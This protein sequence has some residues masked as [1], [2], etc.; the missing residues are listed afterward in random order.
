MGSILPGMRNGVPSTLTVCLVL[1]LIGMIRSAC[2]QSDG[3]LPIFKR[4]QRQVMYHDPANLPPA[5]SYGAD[6]SFDFAPPRLGAPVEYRASRPIS[7]DEAIR[8]AL[9]N[10][11]VVRTLNGNSAGAS[12][13]T[14]YDAAIDNTRIDAAQAAFDPQF[15]LNQNWIQNENP[16]GTID[17]ATGLI[18]QGNAS[19]TYNVNVGVSQRNMLGGQ[20]SVTFNE[21]N[22]FFRPSGAALN[23][24]DTFYAEMNYTQPLLRGAGVT[25]NR[26]PI[27]LARIN[28][29]RSFFQYRGSMQ[30]LVRGVVEGYW[31][32]VAARTDLWA[33]EKQIEQA[34]A[35]L[36]RAEAR[37]RIGLG[38]VTEVTQAKSALASFRAQKI[39]A[40]G[41]VL[42]A[43]AA[44]L[45]VLG[46]PP[47]SPDQ[48]VPISPPTRERIPLS[49]EETFRLAEQR[50]PDILELKLV[51]E[52]DRQ[53]YLLR[54]NEFRPTL[55]ATGRYRWDGL[56]GTAP[57]VPPSRRSTSGGEFTDWQLGIN[58][59]VPLFLR[60]ERANL[61][62]AELVLARDR[63]NI[64]QVV[65]AAEHTLALLLR[66]LD[67]SYLRYE[68]FQEARAAARL[69]LERQLAAS[70]AGTDVIFL[71]VLQAISDWG[72]SVSQEASALLDYN[73]TLARIE[74][75]TGTILETHGIFFVE[76]KR[77]NVGPVWIRHTKN[78]LYPYA[79][80][81]TL[82]DSRYETGEEPAEEFFDLDDYPG[83]DRTTDEVEEPTVNEDAGNLPL[84]ED[85]EADDSAAVI[86]IFQF[87]K[88]S[89]DA[90][91]P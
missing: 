11:D 19:E 54:K 66:Q 39:S 65:H 90:L 25:A 76:D 32:L 79:H 44:L 41:A 33:R 91:I 78:R 13:R 56:T 62:S 43:E 63:A 27:V 6:Y 8:V 69:N 37:L 57:T 49:W 75:E 48:M 3:F 23:P 28:A 10:V 81:P 22:S 1:S 5:S 74:A 42:N 40:D 26:V 7:L 51:W 38:D 60:E 86:P 58:F 71:N 2:A 70:E 83:H 35:A 12:G 14:I 36:E 18:S 20:A 17:G 89:R 55:N 73:T 53:N 46:L 72:N 50:R 29:E 59:S 64:K 21:S 80:R 24:V 77:C 31:S 67:Q 88:R 68:A 34:I 45:N 47:S 82:N 52:A 30:G 9:E 4:E 15:A 85:L 87:L 16:G 84:P 61:R